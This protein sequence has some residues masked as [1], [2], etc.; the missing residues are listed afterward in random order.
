VAACALLGDTRETTKK[1]I[2]NIT[3]SNMAVF[4]IRN[5]GDTVSLFIMHFSTLII[6][7]ML[8]IYAWD[9]HNSK[10]ANS[11]KFMYLRAGQMISTIIFLI[12]YISSWGPD[13]TL[14]VCYIQVSFMQV[15]FTLSKV[16][17]HWFYLTRYRDLTRSLGGLKM[18]L[19]VSICIG[20][21]LQTI[22][23]ILVIV[24]FQFNEGDL[25]NGCEPLPDDTGVMLAA[26]FYVLDLI[27][28]ATLL[29][30]YIRPIQQTA[31][32]SGALD[33]AERQKTLQAVITKS[34]W[35]CVAIVVSTLI[36][37]VGYSVYGIPP[38]NQVTDALIGFTSLVISVCV[39]YTHNKFNAL[40]IDP[41][42]NC[43]QK[44][45]PKRFKQLSSHGPMTGSS[46]NIELK[47]T[48]SNENASKI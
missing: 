11:K 40:Y 17:L 47:N 28:D 44:N 46:G 9:E 42:K 14:E 32:G 35:T 3:T 1:S 27:L 22:V 6:F 8:V 45:A 12:S 21:G 33:D 5:A 48:S 19:V 25:K 23:G 10:N 43:W 24:F 29:R 38:W 26:A 7:V 30:I 15:A 36:V 37:T 34:K 4:A 13:A 20:I 31:G 39:L 16:F 41:F 2:E 18:W